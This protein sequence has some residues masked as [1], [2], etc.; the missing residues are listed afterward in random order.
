MHNMTPIKMNNMYVK[1][2]AVEQYHIK[3]KQSH[4]S[5]NRHPLVAIDWALC[6][7]S[8]FISP[9]TVHLY[10]LFI[11]SHNSGSTTGH[12]IAGWDY[13]DIAGR[14]H[15]SYTYTCIYSS[16][17]SEDFTWC[18]VY[19][20]RVYKERH[21]SADPKKWE[22]N[23]STHTMQQCYLQ[24]HYKVSRSVVVSFIKIR[25][26]CCEEMKWKKSKANKFH[27][28]PL[29]FYKIQTTTTLERFIH[30]FSHSVIQ[31]FQQR[32]H[33]SN[34]FTSPSNE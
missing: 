5:H 17:Y 19:C 25:S 14:G 15:L 24:R 16:I 11:F 4:L 18:V 10:A 28:I 12:W 7:F 30:S 9:L 13:F 34:Q 26:W 27:R 20:R 31:S 23:L 8:L 3:K 29:E 22:K 6:Q 2:S 33:C 21:R 32:R 1:T